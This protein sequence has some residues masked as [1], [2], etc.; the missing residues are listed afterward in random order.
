[1]RWGGKLTQPIVLASIGILA[2]LAVLIAQGGF[3][4]PLAFIVGPVLVVGVV[5]GFLLFST[6]ASRG[7]G[8]QR[9]ESAP[10]RD[11]RAQRL[12]EVPTATRKKR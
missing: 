7:K 6:R 5:L 8:R 3:R 11:D 10:S 1:M 2:L 4:R 9:A 12:A